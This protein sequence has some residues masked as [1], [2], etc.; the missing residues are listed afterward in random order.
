MGRENNRN[1]LRLA[2]LPLWLR[3]INS[4]SH[5]ADGKE[6]SQSRRIKS[7][8]NGTLSIV[9]GHVD[10]EGWWVCSGKNKDGQ[11]VTGSFYIDVVGTFSVTAVAA[12]IVWTFL[13]LEL[14]RSSLSLLPLLRVETRKSPFIAHCLSRQATIDHLL[15]LFTLRAPLML[16]LL[17][18]P[19]SS[20][21]P[22]LLPILSLV[23]R[24]STFACVHPL[25]TAEKPVINPFLFA[26]DLREGMRTT[27]VCSVLS[28][29]P[30]LTFAWIKDGRPLHLAH[31]DADAQRYGEFTSR[32]ITA[33]RFTTFKH[34]ISVFSIKT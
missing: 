20:V 2:L 28:G 1:F 25:V 3:F 9:D 15:M 7:Y 33:N 34:V 17:R 31:P 10:D 16:F 12:A 11:R 21:Y 22:S 32:Y 23:S 24:F 14:G 4:S 13:P 29:E 18:F 5:Q 8:A 6:L 30:P 19:Y 26:S 27:V